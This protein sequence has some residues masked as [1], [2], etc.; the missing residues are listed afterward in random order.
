MA[1]TSTGGS[2]AIS[3]VVPAYNEASGIEALVREADAVL[4][5]ITA[6]FEI[7][8]V[9]DG[10]RDETG[11]ILARLRADVPALRT[12]LLRMNSGQHV[13]SFIGLRAS[14]G[15]VVFLADADLKASLP[16][17]AE[18]FAV[19]QS[20]PAFD[21]ASVVRAN[22]SRELHRAIGSRAVGWLVN[23]MTGTRLLDPASPLRAYR[24]RAVDLISEADVFAQNLPILTSMLG[25]T[26]KEIPLDMPDTGRRSRYRLFDLVNLLLLAF[27]NFS[28]GTRT[29]L[30]MIGLGMVS[31]LLGIMGLFALT[32][33]GIVTQS[34]LSTNLLLLFVLLAVVGLQFVLMGGI[35]YKIERINTNLRFRRLALSVPHER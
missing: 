1:A 32:I 4:R 31:T 8:V 34:Q 25:L 20:D 17:L 13:A 14:L 3:L 33:H 35:A 21:I 9:D 16:A 11:Q 29:V 6:T 27:L 15:N 2:V 19:L 28:A 22:R 10:S 24:R 12:I 23:R 18:L 5:D 7:I 30:T 26:I